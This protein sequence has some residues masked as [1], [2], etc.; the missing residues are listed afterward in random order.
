AATITKWGNAQG[1]RIPDVF[2][3][4]LGLSV[5]DKVS[6][7]IEK[8]RL[9]VTS[10]DELYTLEARLAA[11]DGTGSPKPEWDWGDPAGKEWW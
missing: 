9:I 8:N 3:R 6:L 7:A 11:W 4:Q 2:C 1:I 10:A 5:G